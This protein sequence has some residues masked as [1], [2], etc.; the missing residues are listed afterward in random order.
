V[1]SLAEKG[2][3]VIVPESIDCSEFQL[4]EVALTELYGESQIS[5]GL[6]S[7]YL[8]GVHIHTVDLCGSLG[9]CKD[10]SERSYSFWL[11]GDCVV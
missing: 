1:V 7:K 11:R 8:P 10:D 6:V 3:E 2:E 5:V 9:T 4:Q